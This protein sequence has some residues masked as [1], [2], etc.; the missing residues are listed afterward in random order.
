MRLIKENGDVISARQAI[1]DAFLTNVGSSDF[2]VRGNGRHNDFKVMS[3]VE[4]GYIMH[5]MELIKQENPVAEMWGRFAYAPPDAVQIGAAF[6]V[7]F[8]YAREITITQSSGNPFEDFR[9]G[10]L[11]FS[12]MQDA[13]RDARV[14]KRGKINAKKIAEESGFTELE[15][16]TKYRFWYYA[17]KDKLIDLDSKVLPPVAALLYAIRQRQEGEEFAQNDFIRILRGGWNE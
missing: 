8:P 17:I 1:H 16:R 14:G 4:Q 6:N 11:V 15:F 13:A 12:A 3:Q 9:F 7:I 10:G 2:S 5:M